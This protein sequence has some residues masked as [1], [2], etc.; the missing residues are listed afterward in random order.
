[1][2]NLG[3]ASAP[4]PSPLDEACDSHRRPCGT[5]DLDEAAHDRSRFIV[6][7][8][9]LVRGPE[10]PKEARDAAMTLIGWL[11]RRMPGEAAHALGATRAA[12]ALAARKP[13]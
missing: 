12:D 9:S 4:P 3:F 5:Q 7:I 6:Q 10:C 13:R 8:A 11:A 2:M 1:M